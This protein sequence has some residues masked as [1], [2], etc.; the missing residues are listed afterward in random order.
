M[1][2][3]WLYFLLGSNQKPN[4][5]TFGLFDV[6]KITRHALTRK[7][8]NLWDEYGLKNKIITYVKDES[9]N[10]NKMTNGFESIVKCEAL[11]LKENF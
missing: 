11:N 1:S 4:H 2:L 3:P 5:I 8:T 9:S 6:F 7:L 10:L